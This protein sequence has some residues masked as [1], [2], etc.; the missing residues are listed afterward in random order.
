MKL[1][2][3]KKLGWIF[4]SILLSFLVI[5][6][7]RYILYEIYSGQLL[8]TYS[9]IILFFLFLFLSIIQK[10]K[11]L[12]YGPICLSLFVLYI[13][14]D[15]GDNLSVDFLI[16]TLAAL[17]ALGIKSKNYFLLISS[18]ILS[19]ITIYWG[20]KLVSTPVY[21]GYDN[22]NIGFIN[23]KDYS[24]VKKSKTNTAFSNDTVYLLNFTRTFCLPCKEK[25]PSLE[26]V[27]TKLKNKPF[28]LVNIYFSQDE[29]FKIETTPNTVTFYDKKDL[30]SKKM[31]INGAPTEIILDKNGKIRR[32]MLGYTK[33]LNS[34]YESDTEL[35]LKKLINEK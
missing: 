21:N 14:F 31:K 24:L 9:I 32:T 22:K 13:K 29:T 5:I 26:I 33:E 3:V 11:F 4:L 2:F 12:L 17:T 20:H 8:Y 18:I 10:T 28:K 1:N 7:Y 34:N 15:A 16:I 30:F 35:L 27:A 6:L 25:K 19:V 23:V